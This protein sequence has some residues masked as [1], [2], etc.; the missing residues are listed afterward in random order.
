[1]FGFPEPV[2]QRWLGTPEQKEKVSSSYQRKVEFCK[3]TNTPIWVGEFGVAYP[4]EFRL[5][6]KGERIC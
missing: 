6:S 1:M 4:S 5:L 3:K 2:G